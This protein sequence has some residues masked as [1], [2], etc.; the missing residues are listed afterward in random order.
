MTQLQI[1]GSQVQAAGTIQTTMADFN[2]QPPSAPFVT[3]DRNVTIGFL[4]NLAK[5]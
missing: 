2:I 4:L 1:S 3:V 5:A